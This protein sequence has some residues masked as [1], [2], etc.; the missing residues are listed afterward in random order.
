MT[1]FRLIIIIKMYAIHYSVF[2]FLSSNCVVNIS[3]KENP[4]M[5]NKVQP[6]LTNDYVNGDEEYVFAVKSRPFAC[7][8]SPHLPIPTTSLIDYDLISSLGNQDV[9]SSVS[10]V[11]FWR[12][13]DAYPWQ[14]IPD[15]SDHSGWSLLWYFPHKG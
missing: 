12:P 11:L 5:P 15:C 8:V 1:Y 7:L 10:E 2:I 9:G 14:G 13:Q 4:T 3:G 6:T